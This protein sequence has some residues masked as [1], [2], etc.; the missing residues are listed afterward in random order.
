MPGGFSRVTFAFDIEVH[1]DEHAGLRVESG[2]GTQCD[3]RCVTECRGWPARTTL[4]AM[5]ASQY[6]KY[7]ATFRLQGGMLGRGKPGG[8]ALR[9]AVRLRS[10]F[11]RVVVDCVRNAVGVE[12]PHEGHLTLHT[13]TMA[14]TF[15]WPV[16]PDRV[17]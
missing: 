4:V 11:D 2:W 9:Y 17:M 14:A 6:L 13:D 1:G 10:E 3:E 8:A 16:V 7:L 15:L 5:L 12:V